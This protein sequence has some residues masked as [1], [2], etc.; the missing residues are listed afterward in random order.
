M[1]NDM[2]ICEKNLNEININNSFDAKTTIKNDFT[3]TLYNFND[4]L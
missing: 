1:A 2:Q 4:I 3:I